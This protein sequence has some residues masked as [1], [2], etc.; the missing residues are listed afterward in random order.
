MAR[1][2]A[3]TVAFVRTLA[4]RAKCTKLLHIADLA[5]R[6][7]IPDLDQ[8]TMDDALEALRGEPKATDTPAA[9]ADARIYRFCA[10]YN[11]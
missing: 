5:H 6:F 4:D 1:R 8:W 11:Y 7:D 3:E 2:P 9:A 10:G